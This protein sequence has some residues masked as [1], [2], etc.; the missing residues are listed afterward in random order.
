MVLVAKVVEGR[1]LGASIRLFV[2]FEGRF[3][4]RGHQEAT[5]VLDCF[6]QGRRVESA[7]KRDCKGRPVQPCQDGTDDEREEGGNAGQS[8][9][10]ASGGPHVLV[11]TEEPTVAHR[12]DAS[13]RTEPL[14][15]R[16]HGGG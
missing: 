9:G 4:T 8:E 6:P 1:A 11:C 7:R 16:A 2:A 12:E 15:Q 14:G 3:S 13:G 5:T 10:E